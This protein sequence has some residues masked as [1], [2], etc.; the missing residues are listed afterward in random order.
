MAM[1][2]PSSGVFHFW[3]HPSL[4]KRKATYEADCQVQHLLIPEQPVSKD[5]ED[6]D[7]KLLAALAEEFMESCSIDASI[8]QHLEASTKKQSKSDLW[9]RARIG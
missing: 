5:M 3:D 1:C 2:S 9:R 7:D 8:A 6:I 4:G